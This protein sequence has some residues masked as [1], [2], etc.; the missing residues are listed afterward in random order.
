MSSAGVCIDGCK[1]GTIKSNSGGKLSY[2]PFED[3]QWR[4]C[5]PKGIKVKLTFTEFDVELGQNCDYDRLA[6]FDASN[7]IVGRKR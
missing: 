7:T 5:V 1:P 4:I 6:I 2:R 3:Q